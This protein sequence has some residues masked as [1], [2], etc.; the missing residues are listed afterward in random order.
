MRKLLLSI[1]ALFSAAI[2]LSA[3]ERDDDRFIKGYS[4]GM[5]VHTGYLSGCDNPY[6][7][8]PQGPTFGIGG[9]V[10]LRVTEHF[11]FGAEGYFSNMG[12]SRGVED[13]SFNKFFWTGALC[14]WYWKTGKFY[15]YAGVMVGG[16]M[17]TAFY[18]FDGR[19]DD[20]VREEHVVFNKT[21][22][23]AVDPFVGVE[24]AAGKALHL[25]LKLDWLV[26]VNSSG[27]NRPSGP[28]LYFGFIFAH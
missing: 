21:P 16:G 18:M 22:F 11:R 8:N 17:E 9:L 5:L 19:K 25:T 26:A 23:F 13:G 4:G 28:R 15:P 27:V 7:F 3:V 6:L 14:D 1:A 12:L 2:V 24:Y 10:K 20:W